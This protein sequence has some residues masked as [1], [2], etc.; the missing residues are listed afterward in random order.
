MNSFSPYLCLYAYAAANHQK[1]I[2]MYYLITCFSS[3]L[4]S[5]IISFLS[6]VGIHYL[7]FVSLLS[8][9]T[10]FPTKDYFFFTLPAFTSL[11]RRGRPSFLFSC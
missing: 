3:T 4:R 7:C 1:S 8:C 6:Y 11:L 9:V 2:Y 5:E 10:F